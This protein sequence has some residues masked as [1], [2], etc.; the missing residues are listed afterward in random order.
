MIWNKDI[1]CMC[2]DEMNFWT[3]V[4]E[5]TIPQRFVDLDLRAFELG[6]ITSCKA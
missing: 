3:S 1:E 6:Y 5:R 4:L 2:R